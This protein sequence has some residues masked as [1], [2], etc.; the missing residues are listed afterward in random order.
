MNCTLP[1]P[2]KRLTPPGCWL[3]YPWV[4]HGIKRFLAGS[5]AS[6]VL[7][8]ICVDVSGWLSQNKQFQMQSKGRVSPAAIVCDTPSVTCF[9][10][11]PSYDL[12]NMPTPRL[13][14]GQVSAP[15]CPVHGLQNPP[16]PEGKT[17]FSVPKS[18]PMHV[19]FV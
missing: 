14:S 4:R 12:E 2:I 13:L 3:L 6:R 18:H 9:N 17:D 8:G 11:T 19:L 16:Q 5:S 7:I 10:C 15:V 1:S